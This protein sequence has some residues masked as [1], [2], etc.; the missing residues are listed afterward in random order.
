MPRRA[1]LYLPGYPIHAIQRGHNQMDVFRD[2]ADFEF[3]LATLFELVELLEIELHAYVLMTNHV[4]FLL[5]VKSKESLSLLFQGLGRRYVQRFNHRYGLRG[6][7][8]EGRFRSIPIDSE[9]YLMQVYRY[10]ELNPVRAGIVQKPQEYIYSS[11]GHHIGLIAQKQIQD[12]ALFWSLGNTPYERQA[13]YLAL[14]DEGLSARQIE[15]ITTTTLRGYNLQSQLM[16]PA[17]L[18]LA[19]RR[20][21]PARES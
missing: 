10:I 8:W 2:K 11:Y 6:S 9:R 5:T 1:R 19:C 18:K 20:G 3:Y 12:H 4:H 16:P 15:N 7:L 17:N 14:I 13:A 21:R